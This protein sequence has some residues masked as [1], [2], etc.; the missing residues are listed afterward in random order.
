MNLAGENSVFE[1]QFNFWLSF[2]KFNK[3]LLNYEN[4]NSKF[5]MKFYV[6]LLNY[7]EYA[8]I[9]TF[10]I[11]RFSHSILYLKKLRILKLFFLLSNN[12]CLTFLLVISIVLSLDF[13]LSIIS[14]K[15]SVFLFINVLFNNNFA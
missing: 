8:K 10:L 14:H 6:F 15:I 2:S 7:A 9:G 1:K 3:N 4:K 13:F 5:K 12:G 11:Y